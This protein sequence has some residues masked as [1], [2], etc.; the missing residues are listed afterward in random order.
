[1]LE[2]TD[3]VTTALAVLFVFFVALVNLPNSNKGMTAVRNRLDHEA[4]CANHGYLNASTNTCTCKN[5]LFSAEKIFVGSYN[6]SAHGCIDLKCS[7]NGGKQR[8]PMIVHEEDEDFEKNGIINTGYLTSSCGCDKEGEWGGIGCHLCKSDNACQRKFSNDSQNDSQQWRCDNGNTIYKSKAFECNLVGAEELSEWV[9]HV[10]TVECQR[11]DSA[12]NTSSSSS[13]SSQSRMKCS[14]QT[15]YDESKGEYHMTR[16]GLFQEVLYCSLSD[17]K[18]TMVPKTTHFNDT[19]A[20]LAEYVLNNDDDDYNIEYSCEKSDCACSPLTTKR[21]G[22]IETISS[23]MKGHAAIECDKNMN[24]VMRHETFV[25]M[26]INLRC[27]SSECVSNGTTPIDIPKT[28]VAFDWKYFVVNYTG[29]VFIATLSI[30]CIVQFIFLLINCKAHQKSSEREYKCIR[31]KMTDPVCI[32]VKNLNYS[33][34][35]SNAPSFSKASI[36]EI[37]FFYSGATVRSIF[38]LTRK[39]FSFIGKTLACAACWPCNLIVYVAKKT[40]GRKSF[41]QTERHIVLVDEEDDENERAKRESEDVEMLDRDNKENDPPEEGYLPHSIDIRNGNIVQNRFDWYAKKPILKDASVTLRPGEVNV[42]IGMSGSS[43]T[44]FLDILSARSKVGEVSGKIMVNDMPLGDYYKRITSYVYQTDFLNKF[45]TGEEAIRFSADLRLPL[46]MSKSEKEERIKNLV[47]VLLL[48]DVLDGRIGDISERGVSGGEKKRLAI[49]CELISNPSV[50]VLDEPTTGLDSINALSLM[51]HLKNI[52]RTSGTTVILSI[53]QPSKEMFFKYFDH[54]VCMHNGR[55]KFEGNPISCVEAFNLAGYNVNIEDDDPVNSILEAMHKEGDK[56]YR[57]EPRSDVPADEKPDTTCNE[58]QTKNTNSALSVQTTSP[59]HQTN[60]ISVSVDGENIRIEENKTKHLIQESNESTSEDEQSMEEH[61]AQHTRNSG[62]LLSPTIPSGSTLDHRVVLDMGG[63][64]GMLN[65][66]PT[67][68]ATTSKQKK[69]GSNTLAKLIFGHDKK[70]ISGFKY[71][72]ISSYE[73]DE[74]EI[75]KDS[76]MN[77]DEFNVYAT[78]FLHQLVVT[79]GRAF[80]NLRRDKS[81]LFI[82]LAISVAVGLSLGFIFGNSGLDMEGFRK[83]VGS[84]S[85]IGLF[86]SLSCV[87]SLG[88]FI[89]ERVL[90]SRELKNGYYHPVAYYMSKMIVDIVPLRVIP[91]IVMLAIAYP[92]LNLRAGLDHWFICLLIFSLFNICYGSISVIVGSLFSSFEGAAI[93]AVLVSVFSSIF[94]GTWVEHS[95]MPS[96]VSW[97]AYLSPWSYSFEALAVNELK[98]V[99][100]LMNFKGLKNLPS[101]HQKGEVLLTEFGMNPDSL[102]TNIVILSAMALFFVFMGGLVLRCC[103]KEKI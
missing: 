40:R 53:Q 13:S 44:T 32:K 103:V 100:I 22:F 50:L 46:C 6:E 87:T 43:K 94:S 63:I 98:G 14:L 30:F 41:T 54:V 99:K 90:Y 2:K 21:N 88:P 64:P 79:T 52:S 83:R 96:F 76:K 33:I 68:M 67:Q 7:N 16:S 34:W 69:G 3:I 59:L 62:I 10:M 12:S 75:V 58:E 95:S 92:M 36:S 89:R 55:V 42:F 91:T 17:C 51:N 80:Q 81:L 61:N 27:H 38:I 56:I 9:G 28:E 101:L 65:L 97:M 20:S 23:S 73:A 70:K 31:N 29:Y 49:A 18:M 24:C 39:L 77:L 82:H 35:V 66:T 8:Q 19:T 48:K 78:P 74:L 1:M 60:E 102:N 84:L 57:L 71:V 15:W 86:I 26:D 5:E 47:D 25:G 45:S 37:A 93:V 4:I 11:D 72:D 85:Y